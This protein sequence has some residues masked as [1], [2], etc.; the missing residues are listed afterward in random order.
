MATCLIN[1]DAPPISGEI[2]ENNKITKF[3]S[4]FKNDDNQWHLLLF[5]PLDFTFVCPTELI[6]FS[7]SVSKF[8]N[9]NTKVIG[10][11]CDSTY[12]HHAWLNTSRK[13]GGIQNL[14]FSL[15]SDVSHE[16]SKKYGAFLEEES[17]PVRATFIIDPNGKIRHY[18]MNHMPVG[19]NVDEYLRLIEGYQ[20]TDAN[21]VVCPLN[22][23][24]GDDTIIDNPEDKLE[25]FSKHN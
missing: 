25:Y 12:V 17:H 5:Y 1:K 3:N 11:S 7:N 22:W 16:V 4:E 6:G 2:V 23:K 20:F 10:I 13:N 19:R 18:S 24:K 15:F 14:N 8:S 21:G 9:I